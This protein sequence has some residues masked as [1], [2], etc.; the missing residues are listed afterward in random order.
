M[1]RRRSES[2][3]RTDHSG[4]MQKHRGPESRFPNAQLRI[5]GLVLRTIPE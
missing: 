5:Q 2:G 3:A 1:K 4:A